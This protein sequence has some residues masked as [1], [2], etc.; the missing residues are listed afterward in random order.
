MAKSKSG[1]SQAKAGGNRGQ[2]SEKH[3]QEQEDEPKKKRKGQSGEE[4]T[5][6][7]LLKVATKKDQNKAPSMKTLKLAVRSPH[8]TKKPSKKLELF[9]V[10]SD[11]DE[12]HDGASSGGD[13]VVYESGE[14]NK[15]QAKVT[16][17][18]ARK[19]ASRKRSSIVWQHAFKKMP[20]NDDKCLV[21]LFAIQYG[22]IDKN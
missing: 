21:S 15:P 13:T 10:D 14:Q 5:M 16:P 9:G 6:N 22:L 1:K 12:E 19:R 20:S 17:K 2:K 18:S 8:A 7:K 11:D 3:Q 4:R